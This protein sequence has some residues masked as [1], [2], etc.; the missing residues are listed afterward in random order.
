MRG[1]NLKVESVAERKGLREKGDAKKE[2][3][4]SRGWKP[5]EGGGVRDRSISAGCHLRLWHTVGQPAR[6]SSLIAHRF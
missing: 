2:E 4:R 3:A 5:A 6:F 1:R